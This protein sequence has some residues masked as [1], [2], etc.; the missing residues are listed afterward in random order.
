[1]ADPWEFGS[2]DYSSLPSFVSKFPLP[3]SLF[4]FTHLQPEGLLTEMESQAK[5]SQQHL[6]KSSKLIPK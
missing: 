1:M 5:L 3:P 6:V 4:Y 2:R